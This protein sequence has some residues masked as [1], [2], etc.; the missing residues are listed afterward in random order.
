MMWRLANGL[1]HALHLAVILF[2]VLGW[3]WP[4]TRPWHLA[5]ASLIAFSWFVL[6]P[7]VGKFGFCFLTGV[8]HALWRKVGV[9]DSTNYMSYLARRLTGRE[10]NAARINLW[11]QWVFYATTALSAY[12]SWRQ[13]S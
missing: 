1:L 3:I 10:P 11:T 6:G 4:S 2:S 7:L 12:L 8:Q 9:S 5:L 13:R